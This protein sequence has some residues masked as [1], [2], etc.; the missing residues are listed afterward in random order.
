MYFF[1]EMMQIV[2]FGREAG[3]DILTLCTIE[4]F[5]VEYR[6]GTFYL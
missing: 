4:Y 5:Q 1:L 3:A 6:I 2:E